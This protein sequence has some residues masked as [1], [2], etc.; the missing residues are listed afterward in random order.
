MQ[1]DQV[2][3]EINTKETKIQKFNSIE[4]KGMMIFL[5]LA[6]SLGFHL[7]D[8]YFLCSVGLNATEI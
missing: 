8:H 1:T 4:T 2:S 7:F 5:S 3:K 6:F